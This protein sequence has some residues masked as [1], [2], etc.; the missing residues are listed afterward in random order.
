MTNL[1]ETR[2][3]TMAARM[4]AFAIS[5]RKVSKAEKVAL[6]VQALVEAERIVSKEAA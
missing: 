6:M 5:G 3:N 1:N 2:I 4:V